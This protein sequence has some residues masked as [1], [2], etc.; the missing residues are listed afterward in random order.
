M[1]VS[2]C[3]I[4]LFLSAIESFSNIFQLQPGTTI[5][6][7]IIRRIDPSVGIY[8]STP[9]RSQFL[10]V[11]ASRVG[12]ERIEKLERAFQIAQEVPCRILGHS[13]LDGLALATMKPSA[14]N[15]EIVHFGDV[16]PTLN[17][18]L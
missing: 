9:D 14:L 12:D 4:C 10:F 16:K 6:G 3:F 13:L 15:E 5:Q 18:N 11:H 8:L 2:F 1:R 7:C 17:A